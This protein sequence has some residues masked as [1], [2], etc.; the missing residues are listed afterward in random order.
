MEFRRIKNTDTR[1]VFPIQKNDGTFITSAAGLDSEFALL[2]AHGAG[3][4]SFGDCTHEATEIGATGLYYLDLSAAEVNDDF[5]VVQVKSSTTGAITQ[6]LLVNTTRYAYDE[7]VLVHAHAANADTQTVAATLAA[8][9]LD[10]SLTSP[11]HNTANTVGAQL[12]LLTDIDS[13]TDRIKEGGDLDVVIDGIETHVHSIE[14]KVGAPANTGG[15]ASLAAI[16]GNPANVSLSTTITE[17]GTDTDE[18]IAALPTT[19]YRFLIKV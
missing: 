9:I 1:I 3:A 13:E 6:V 5:S 15:T 14:S 10:H 19:S 2:G 12:T 18:I 4:P 16:L 8:A 17:I 11:A 7:A